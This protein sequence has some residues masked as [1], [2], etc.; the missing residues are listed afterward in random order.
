MK[1]FFKYL[2]ASVLGVIVASILIFLISMGVISAIVS[3]QDKPFEVKPKS[4][5]MLKLDQPV[6]DRKPSMPI[7][8]FGLGGFGIDN[9]IG[10]NELLSNIKKAASDSNICGIYLQLSALQSGIATIEEIR[11]ALI[12]FKKSGKFLISY[13]DYYTQTAYYLASVS[14][15]VYLNPLGLVNFDGLSAEILFFKKAFEKLDIEPQII[16]H[17]KFKSAVEPLIHE[18]MSEEN[19]EQIK[20]YIGSIWKHMVQQTSLSRGLS[21]ERINEL[22]DNMAIGIAADALHAG[23]V[24]SILYKD[25]VL[26]ELTRLSKVKSSKK[27]NLVTHNQ[28]VKAPKTRHHKGLA[29]DKIAVIYA[30]GSIYEGEDGGENIASETISRTI[31]EAREDSSIKAIVFRV[32]SGGGS[33]L[34][35]EVIW[36]EVAL[37]GRVKPVVASMGDLAASGGYYILAAADTVLASP[38]TLTGSIGVFGV[39]FNTRDFLSSKLGITADV[40]KTNRHSDLGSPFRPLDAAER[41]YMQR[42]IDNIYDTF[43]SHVAEGRKLSKAAVDSIGEGR[44]WSGINAREIGLVDGYGG[45]T[46]AIEIA[47]ARTGL[48][49]YRV[50]ELPKQKDPLEQILTE[51]SGGAGM[52]AMKQEFGSVYKYYFQFTHLVNSA[53]IMARLPFEVEIY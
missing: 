49:H 34:A 44:V 19:R 51:L 39:L 38:N 14:D 30:S 50:V 17:G 12:E 24:D 8:T 43:I 29:R 40:E 52:R 45:L 32:N 1:S 22:A 15:K 20:T 37:A 33:A 35:S 27:L 42:M 10:L 21:T 47:A 36:R 16:R 25:Q 5:L 26:E 2:L 3:S 41:E 13:S 18:E 48:D 28:Y 6:I 11:E 9:R 53:G 4:I 23:L 46:R 31:R 7:P